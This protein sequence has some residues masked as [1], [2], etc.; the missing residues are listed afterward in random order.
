MKGKDILATKGYV[1]SINLF[2]LKKNDD[3]SEIIQGFAD[4]VTKL[5]RSLESEK[6]FL[7]GNLAHI[8][9]EI[10]PCINNM[11]C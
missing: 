1:T 8:R 5:N 7:A 9:G 6:H 10:V 2:F 4:G 3:L 11:C